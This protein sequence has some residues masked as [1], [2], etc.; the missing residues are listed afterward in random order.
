MGEES[1]KI[2][3]VFGS[4][5]RSFRTIDRSDFSHQSLHLKLFT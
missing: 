5:L 1:S 2:V 4:V 3:V